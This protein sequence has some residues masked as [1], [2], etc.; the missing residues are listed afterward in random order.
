MVADFTVE[1]TYGLTFDHVVVSKVYAV[2][3]SN[4]LIINSQDIFQW[5]PINSCRLTTDA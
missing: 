3:G 1:Y 2:E 5:V 4:F